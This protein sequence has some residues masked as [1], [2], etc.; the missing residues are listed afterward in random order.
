MALLFNEE[1]FKIGTYDES[2]RD[3]LRRLLFT[4]LGEIPGF[5]EIGSRLYLYFHGPCDE[6]AANDILEEC[7][8]LI[9]TYEPRVTLKKMLVNFDGH[10]IQIDINYVII[11]DPAQQDRTAQFYETK[12][13][14]I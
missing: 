6:Q 5:P 2:V 13:L 9:Q 12:S 7:T 4:W 3:S 10:G 14:T 8:F 11:N 1:E